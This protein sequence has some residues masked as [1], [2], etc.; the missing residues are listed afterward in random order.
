MIVCVCNRL[1]EARIRA[2]AKAG[3]S[4]AEDVYSHCGVE[5]NCG[6]CL[7]EIEAILDAECPATRQAAE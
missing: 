1:N 7:Q 5:R 6:T 2:A 4:I 3:V